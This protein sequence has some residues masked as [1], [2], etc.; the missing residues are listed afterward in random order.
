VIFLS[1]AQ[2]LSAFIAGAV[3]IDM[4]TGNGS[5]RELRVQMKG[6]TGGDESF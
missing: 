6:N 5:G 2:G 3:V 4:I 1:A